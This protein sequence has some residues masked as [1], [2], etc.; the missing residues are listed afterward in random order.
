MK[1]II[2]LLLATVSFSASSLAQGKGN[3]EFGINTGLNTSFRDS[4][5]ENIDYR[6]SYN[7]GASLDFY[8]SDRWSIK[9]K[10]I[11]DNKGWNRD[12]INIDGDTY[13]TNI[14]LNYIT[15]PVMANWHFGRKRNWYLNFGPYVGFLTKAEDTRFGYDV[16]DNI[17]NTDFGIAFGLGVKIPL[18]NMLKLYFEYEAQSGI[19]N[20]FKEDYT[21][22]YYNNNISNYRGAFN[23]GL[24]F[25]IK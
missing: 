14:D 16:K 7:V 12:Y 15:V 19:S 17:E 3:I 20:V 22:S 13:D 4:Y 25:L 6:T 21:N 24:N 5:F 10:G 8:F 2:F 23:V 11:Y 18:N 9:V 1:K